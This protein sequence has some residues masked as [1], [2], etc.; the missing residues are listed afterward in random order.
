MHKPLTP[1]QREENAQTPQ[2]PQRL[3][4]RSFLLSAGLATASTAV[5]LSGC[6][7][8]LDEI[9]DKVPGESVKQIIQLTGDDIGVLNYAY[10]LEQLEAAFY[11]EAIASSVFMGRL[12]EKDRLFF[13]DI[14]K[15]EVIHREFFKAVLG[16]NAIPE[17]KFNFSSI[18]FS[19][20]NQVLQ[21]AKTFEDLGV[22]AYNGAG[23]LLTNVENLILA[24]KIVSVEARHASYIREILGNYDPAFTDHTSFAGDDV[25]DANG[26]DRA[27][28]P[29]QVLAAAAPF[30][31]YRIDA[32]QLM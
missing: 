18:N 14:Q 7:T 31:A 3:Q 23:E 30:I 8:A 21:T 4:R 29:A 25:I 5:L 20:R 24:G 13:M 6:G 12:T 1:V 10:T 9:L 19:N 2:R 11:S 22:A 28:P 27:L 15:H 26:L 17:L 16:K 32:S